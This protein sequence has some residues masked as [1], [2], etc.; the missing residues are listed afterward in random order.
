MSMNL[1][2]KGGILVATA[3]LCASSCA[4]EKKPIYTETPSVTVQQA[5]M[6]QQKTDSVGQT[7]TIVKDAFPPVA[8]KE[9]MKCMPTIIGGAKIVSPSTGKSET[10]YGNE[11]RADIEVLYASGATVRIGI[12]DYAGHYYSVRERYEVPYTEVGGE[13][14]SVTLGAG[15]GFQMVNI[16]EKT[17]AIRFAVSQRFGIDVEVLRYT[18]EFGSPSKVL[19]LLDLQLLETI[20]QKNVKK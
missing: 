4:E 7:K 6:T 20:A 11:T 3:L 8:G 13:V 9:L 10:E 2:K 16:Y 18:Q 14:T 17:A 1:R 5:P 12:T 15:K 19:E